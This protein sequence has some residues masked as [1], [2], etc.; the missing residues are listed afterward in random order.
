MA[1]SDLKK[2]IYG[3]TYKYFASESSLYQA[4][5]RAKSI[6]KNSNVYSSVKKDPREFASTY[7]IY[8][9]K[10]RRKK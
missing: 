1:K 3:K 8:I 10:K 2:R 9:R 7:H 6:R 5:K 4:K